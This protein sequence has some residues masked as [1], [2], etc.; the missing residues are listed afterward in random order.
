MPTEHV[1]P[2]RLQVAALLL[3][4]SYRIAGSRWATVDPLKRMPRPNVPELEPAYYDL[5]EADLEQVVNSGSFV[6]PRPRVAAHADPGAAR[7]VLPQHRLRVHVHQRPRAARVD[8]GAHRAGARHAQARRRPAEAPAR[9]ADRGRAARALPAHQVR[10]AEALLARRRREP[11][12]V[13]RR[14]DPARRR[15]RRAGDR[16]R[17]GAPRPAQRPGQRARQDA[18]GP[19]PRVRGQARARAADGRRQVPQR[20][21][22]RH[23]HAGRAGPPLARVQ[24]VAPRDRQPGGRGLGASAPAPPRRQDRRPGAADPGARRRR[25]RRAG[26]GDGDAQPL[27][28][29]AATAPAARCT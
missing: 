2:E 14:P 18:E 16:H 19:V 21:L 4:T 13:D 11:D 22:L 28:A 26:R 12:P 23:H 24:P 5:S 3:V 8:P 29:R 10:R 20:L 25:V 6:G 9:Q 7:H 1:A 27:A 17:H 15:Q